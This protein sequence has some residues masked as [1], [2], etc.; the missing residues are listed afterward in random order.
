MVGPA[1]HRPERNLTSVSC[2]S[3]SFCAAV[4]R[5]GNALSFDGSTWSAPLLIDSTGLVSVS[6]PS[7]SFCAAVEYEDNAV[8][9][10]GS[11][12]STPQPIDTMKNLLPVSCASS[13]FCVA[14]H[15]T[16][17]AIIGRA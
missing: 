9:F 8:S 7:S 11:S 4:D 2:V 17:T 16:G 3:S 13:S 1:D 6:C 5:Q 15:P 12:W 10:D 14:V